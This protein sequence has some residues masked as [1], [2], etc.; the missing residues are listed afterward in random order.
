MRNAESME[1]TELN[2]HGEVQ[3]WQPAVVVMMMMMVMMMMSMMKVYFQLSF[4]ALKFIHGDG[5][6]FAIFSKF[7]PNGN[8]INPRPNIFL[9]NGLQK[10]P[11][12][13]KKR[14]QTLMIEA[15]LRLA[16][17]YNDIGDDDSVI[18]IKDIAI[19]D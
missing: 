2:I 5:Q 18:L 15:W 9:E 7:D 10:L 16:T 13:Q 17:Y 14:I 6:A 4:P 1:G 8:P 11:P 19:Y 12:L 3:I